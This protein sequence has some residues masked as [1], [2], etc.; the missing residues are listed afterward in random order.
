THVTLVDGD[1]RSHVLAMM[2]VHRDSAATLAGAIP[3]GLEPGRW[4]VTWRTAGRDGHPV[5]GAFD[6][7]VRAAAAA[8][9]P[10]WTADA[11]SETVADAAAGAAAF[12]AGSP[13]YVLVRWATYLSLV[14]LL[15]ALALLVVVVPRLTG[16]DGA[17]TVRRSIARLGR[18]TALALLVVAFARLAAQSVSLHGRAEAFDGASIGSV[19][20]YTTWGWAWLLQVAAAALAVA[21]C[22]GAPPVGR[23]RRAA[24]VVLLL[25]LGAASAGSGHAVAGESDTTLLVAA[26]TLHT[27]GAGAWLG[28][29]A[30]LLVVVLT[31]TRA[32]T[33]AA[34]SVVRAFAP[35]ALGGAGLVVA[36]GGVL[37]WH[38][39][40]AL[41][42]LVGTIYGRLLLAKVALLAGITVLGALNWRRIAP[43]LPDAGAARV[44]QRSA[45]GELALGAVLLLATAVL[46]ATPTPREAADEVGEP[47]SAVSP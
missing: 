9:V 41:S 40:G 47:T 34:A 14:P 39:V 37:A 45:R 33:P 29:L 44:L 16:G 5:T 38:H 10:A 11:P 3:A 28:A 42:A 4:R 13:L 1:G 43:R 12:D 21:L 25:A 7:T 26:D 46:V 30:V 24:C 2:P 6:F 19:L 8:E 31:G 18:A 36:S 32:A 15:G 35:L 20:R 23:G 17:D 22:S 27:V